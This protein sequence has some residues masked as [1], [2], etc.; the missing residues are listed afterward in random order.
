[1]IGGN[2]SAF[3]M[4]SGGWLANQHAAQE[5]AREMAQ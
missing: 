1:M 3:E 2:A 5:M 4:S